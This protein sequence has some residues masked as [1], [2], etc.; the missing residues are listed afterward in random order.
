MGSLQG[1][2]GNF[3]PFCGD[4][5]RVGC[6]CWREV[7]GEVAAAELETVTCA[8]PPLQESSAV[9]LPASPHQ[10]ALT[11]SKGA[12]WDCFFCYQD[13]KQA[14]SYYKGVLGQGK[15]N[16]FLIP[17]FGGRSWKCCLP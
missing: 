5:S 16:S 8:V 17:V 6:G 9:L 4:P 12:G 3:S 1:C 14:P 10:L 7:G 15:I 2:A 11:E 13:D